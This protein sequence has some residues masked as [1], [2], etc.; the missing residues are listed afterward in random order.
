MLI[1][2]LIPEIMLPPCDHTRETVNVIG[3]F[4]ADIGPVLPYLNATRPKALYNS[5]AGI[6]RF[7][8]EGHQVTL[9]P[10]QMALGGFEDGDKAMAALFRLQQ[11]INETWERRDEI[12]PSTLERKRLHPLA[13]YKMLPGTNCQACGEPTCFVF[14]NKLAAGQVD[15]A[16]CTTLC[17]DGAYARERQQLSTMLETAV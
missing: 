9:Q 10:N 16:S 17:Y 11:L 3:R 4:Q 14:A 13:V 8:F 15:M 5:A 7:R 12:T 1:Q 2:S 6:L